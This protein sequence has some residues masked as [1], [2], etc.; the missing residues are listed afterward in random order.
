MVSI[1]S[2]IVKLETS[3]RIVSSSI[4]AVPV[5]ITQRC[6][7]ALHGSGPPN[8]P[9][10]Y[11]TTILWPVFRTVYLGIGKFGTML[12]SFLDIIIKI[13]LLFILQVWA[14]AIAITYS[15][16][17]PRPGNVFCNEIT[18]CQNFPNCSETCSS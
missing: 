14:R 8:T 15:S 12:L 6:L 13:L 11:Y 7:R 18:P 1:D 5:F 10:R 17:Y 3:R 9:A 4:I 16:S 2:V